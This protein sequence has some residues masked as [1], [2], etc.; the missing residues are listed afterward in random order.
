[1]SRSRAWT[2]LFADPPSPANFNPD[3]VT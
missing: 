1:M 2:V 3:E